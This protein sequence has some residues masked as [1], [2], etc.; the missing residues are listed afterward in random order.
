MPTV[1]CAPIIVQEAQDE[2]EPWFAWCFKAPWKVSKAPVFADSDRH[3]FDS[4]SASSH[5]I[6]LLQGPKEG[7]QIRSKTK[8]VRSCSN[9]AF[10]FCQMRQV[11]EN[12]KES[13]ERRHLTDERSV[14]DTLGMIG[15]NL[16]VTPI[17]V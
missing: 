5:C 7:I 3:S 16:F 8:E 9:S 14:Q 10:G 15:I 11:L 2:V 13:N 4:T 1:C 17:T 12:T 6:C